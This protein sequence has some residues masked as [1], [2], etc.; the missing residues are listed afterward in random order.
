MIPRSARQPPERQLRRHDEI[1]P[2]AR[3]A[4]AELRQLQFEPRATA[5]AT[6]LVYALRRNGSELVLKHLYPVGSRA[7]VVLADRRR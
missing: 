4:L 2:Q 6:H 7:R 3:G 1:Q 5:L